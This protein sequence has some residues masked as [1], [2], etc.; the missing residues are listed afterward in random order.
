MIQKSDTIERKTWK[1]LI[2]S[3]PDTA[4]DLMSKL[5]V[6]EPSKRLTAR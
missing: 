4:I 3:A 5:M 1:E 2:P 6:Y